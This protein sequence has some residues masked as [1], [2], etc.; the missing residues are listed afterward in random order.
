M[1]FPAEADCM[2]TVRLLDLFFFLSCKV[3]IARLDG[4]IQ[5]GTT[6]AFQLAK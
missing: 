2:V 3:V 4:S 1:K 6:G 5:P